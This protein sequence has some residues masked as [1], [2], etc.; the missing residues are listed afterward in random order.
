MWAQPP[1]PRLHLPGRRGPAHREDRRHGHRGRPRAGLRRPRG[2]HQPV[3]P[4]RP[5]PGRPARA[6]ARRWCGC[7]PSATSAAAAPTSTCR[8]CTTTPG[9]IQLYRKLGFTRVAAVCVKRKN[10]INTPLFAARP[11]GLEDLNPYARII[12]EEALRRG[13]RVEVTDAECGELRLSVGGRTVLTRESL[14]EFTTAVAHE[15]LRRQAGHP[16]DHGARRRPRRPR[17]AGRA[18]A[19]WPTPPALLREVG[20]VVVKPARGEQGRGHHRRRH[21]T[22][23]GW[24]G[25]STWR[26]SSAPTCWSRSWCAGDDL[27][28]VVIDRQVVAAAV[29][30]PAEVVGDGRHPVAE[31]VRVA[32]AA[33]GSGRPAAS[34][35]SRW[36]TTT[37]EVVA[38]AGYAMDD[39]PPNGER[40]RV[41]R[42]ANLHTGGTIEDVTDRLHPEIAAAA[43]RAADGAGHPGHRPR[44]PGARRRRARL[45]V[46]RGQ[47]AAR[48]G[49]PRA[50]ARRP[51]GSSTCSSPRPAA[52]DRQWPFPAASRGPQVV[53]VRG[54]SEAELGA[55]LVAVL[56]RPRHRADASRAWPRTAAR[57]RAAPCRRPRRTR[58]RSRLCSSR[59]RLQQRPDRRDAGVGAG[60]HR[61][62]LVAGAARR[63][64]SVNRSRSAGHCAGR[65]G[66]AATRRRPGPGR[67][68]S[69]A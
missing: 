51:S 60:E 50:A 38:D 56:A 63:T 23:P 34:R 48:A 68:S 11:P 25:R 18:R 67:R 44:L 58:P 53:P 13:I 39:V 35:A 55:D 30:R 57:R 12:A 24:S 5:R 27:R 17:G 7:S 61:P 21:A 15:P 19:T 46:H 65:R 31:L 4:R 9:A 47:R 14:S 69:A 16:P 49:Q 6:P 29:R 45:R 64:T 26:C 37:A 22:R 59:G 28:V 36:T 54:A 32:P 52:A 42:T 3:V 20:E 2:R 10:P 66:R 43:V 8:S 1:H 41:R 62:P 40:I 33:G